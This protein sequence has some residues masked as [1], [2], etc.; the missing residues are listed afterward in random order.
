MKSR[1]R[2]NILHLLLDGELCVHEVAEALDITESSASKHL[3]KL[4]I[5]T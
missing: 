2:R 5:M 4:S 3:K 1:E